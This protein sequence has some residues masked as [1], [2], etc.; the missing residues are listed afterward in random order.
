MSQP[1][2]N[3][4]DEKGPDKHEEKSVE[5]KWRSDPISSVSWAVFLIWAGVVLLLHNI[6]QVG[7]L[8]QF[9]KDL[10]IPLNRPPFP[11]PFVD[12]RVWQ[13]FFL[14]A[15]A[16]VSLEVILRL[17][18]PMYRGPVVGS[19]IWA[20]V[21]L[22]LALWNWSLVVPLVIIAIG[23]VVLLQGVIGR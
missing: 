2:Y 23:L 17:L 8:V 10:G 14:G 6:G 16:L 19:M 3:E 21:L 22:G 7:V 1:V 4:K 9:V 20:G 18:I 12:V 5:E 13:V 11:L 15:A